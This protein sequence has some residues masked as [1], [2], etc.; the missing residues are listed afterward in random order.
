MSSQSESSRIDLHGYEKGCISYKTFKK[1][2]GTLEYGDN[3]SFHP[4]K[5]IMTV[6]TFTTS[7]YKCRKDEIVF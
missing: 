2:K 5:K 6:N 3:K 1:T 7:Q 4:V